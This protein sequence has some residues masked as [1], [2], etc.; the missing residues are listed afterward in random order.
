MLSYPEVAKNLALLFVNGE[1]D[2]RQFPGL[3][4]NEVHRRSVKLP[5]SSGLELHSN[6]PGTSAQCAMHSFLR[7][8]VESMTSV[9]SLC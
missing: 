7:P 3:L 5:W 2:L 8:E 9:F 4:A 6:K 1:K